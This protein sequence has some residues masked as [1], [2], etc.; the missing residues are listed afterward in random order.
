M[1]DPSPTLK[2]GHTLAKCCSPEPG[3]R[4]VGYVNYQNRIVVHKASCANLKKIQAARRVSLSWDQISGHKEERPGRDYFKL[5]GLDFLILEHHKMMG[6]DYSLMV[7]RALKVEPVK[8]FERHR[9]LRNMKLLDR[10]KKV[11]I[12]YRKGIVERK[13]IKHRNHT[14]YGIT[15][16]GEKYLS[17]F[18]AQ[19]KR[20]V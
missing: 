3:D 20:R 5:G 11:M 14:Y 18:L 1:S 10:V 17:F 15:P 4:I 19:T 12:Q 7:A 2:E 9:K 6:V 13:W 16:K 8:V